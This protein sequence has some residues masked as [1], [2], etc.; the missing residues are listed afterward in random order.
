M[1]KTLAIIG[2]GLIGG[3]LA[4]ALKGFEDYEIV[5]VD[6]SQPTLRYASEHG[7]GDRVTERAADV[8]PQADV[9]VLALHPQGILDFLTEHRDRF[10]PGA[11]VWDVC[12]IKTA[13]LEGAA[14]LPDTVDFVGCHPMAGTE[15]S[16]VEHAF[17][18]MFR[19]SHFL[20][21]PRETSRPEHL[22]LLERMAAWIG[23]KD[24]YRTTPEAHDALI[25]YTSQVM[26]IIAVAVCD[27]PT[28]FD[29]KGYEGSSFRGCTRVAA[30]DVG[31]WT[32]L[33]SLN[34]PALL[35]VLD[36]LI[37]NL[38]S[39]REVLASG[40]REALAKKLAFSAARKRQM[41]LPGPDLLA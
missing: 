35:E 3:S 39:Y 9:V 23:C 40:D 28:L 32:Q 19:D 34:Q 12:G 4:I 22:A 18:E 20:M 11:L 1:K 15:F 30:L 41:D 25:A 26:H 10:K 7:V 24:V 27:D 13:I 16:G 6:V 33:F 8:L 2:L 21:V 36:R 38:Q 14:A 37:G 31:L 5:G 17:G 29:C